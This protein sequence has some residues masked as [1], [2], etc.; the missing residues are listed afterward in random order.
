MQEDNPSEPFSEK[1]ATAQAA[2]VEGQPEII[3]ALSGSNAANIELWDVQVHARLDLFT[4]KAQRDAVSSE[5]VHR[6]HLISR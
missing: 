5:Y 1:V 2:P 4:F 3:V 6:L